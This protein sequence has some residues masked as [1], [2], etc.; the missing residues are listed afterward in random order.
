M[1]APPQLPC[2]QDKHHVGRGDEPH[3]EIHHVPKGWVRVLL[4]VGGAAPP[5]KGLAQEGLLQGGC[6]AWVL[7]QLQALLGDGQGAKEDIV[8]EHGQ[9]PLEP[10]V[11]LY[12]QCAALEGAVVLRGRRIGEGGEGRRGEG[13]EGRR[14]EGRRGEGGEGRGG[15]GR[16]ERGGEGRG[17]EGRE[18]RGG[19]R[20]EGGEGR[21]ERGGR[22]GEGGEGREE[23]GG[24]RGEGG[25][26]RERKGRRGDRKT[27][28]RM[29]EM[30]EDRLF[31]HVHVE[32]L[33][34][35][36]VYMYK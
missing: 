21:E 24:R 6:E 13:G 20:G 1:H 35:M 27:K 8:G 33:S 19:R 28:E 4:V 14:G 2:R 10:P 25:E 9:Q 23:R 3:E 12:P 7:P 32:Q 11:L 36:Y 5:T 17:G 16:E 30:R 29:E 26:G 34:L 31:I 22:R 18:E 15:E